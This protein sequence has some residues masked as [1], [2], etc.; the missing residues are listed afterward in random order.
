[1][2]GMTQQNA[3]TAEQAG[4]TA[5]SL[6]QQAAELAQAISVF[7]VDDAEV[8]RTTAPARERPHLTPRAPVLTAVRY[9]PKKAA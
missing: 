5:N 8:R 9:I 3:A 4:A 2:H 6:R 1:M 7:V